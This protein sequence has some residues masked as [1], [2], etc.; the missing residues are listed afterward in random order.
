MCKWPSGLLQG[1]RLASFCRILLLAEGR[2]RV[3]NCTRV[4]GGFVDVVLTDQNEE[5]KT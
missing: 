1:G 5:I 3:C 2:R 4:G